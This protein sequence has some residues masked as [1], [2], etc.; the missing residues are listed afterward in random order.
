MGL[1]SFA[2]MLFIAALVFT[3]AGRLDYWQGW[4]Y[5]GING[6]IL[7]ANALVLRK[8]AG[9]LEE[10]LKPG[11]GMKSWDKAYF[12]LSTPLYFVVLILASLDTGRFGWGEGLPVYTYALSVVVYLLGQALFLWAKLVNTYFATVVRIQAERGQTVCKD[13]PYRTVRHP[14]YVGGMLFTFTTPLLLGSLW[15]LLPAGIFV[16]LMLVRTALEDR[17]L[18]AELPGY[19]EYAA[20]VRYRLLPGVW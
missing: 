14:G 7:V 19:K 3:C 10:R 12:A 17:T 9:L 11:K 15:G 2:S 18:L 6:L 8:N 16:L 1:R 20:E 5:V 13:G 4:V